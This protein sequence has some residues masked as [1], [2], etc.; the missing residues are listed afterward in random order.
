M[1]REDS[2]WFTLGL[3]AF[4]LTVFS[5]IVFLAQKSGPQAI[6]WALVVFSFCVV[7]FIALVCN[8]VLQYNLTG[9]PI[10]LS[11]YMFVIAVPVVLLIIAVLVSQRGSELPSGKAI[12]EE[13]HASSAWG[14]G[15]LTIGLVTLIL[16]LRLHVGPALGPLGLVSIVF[17]AV[18]GAGWSG[19][20]YYF[21]P[22]GV[23]VRALGFRLST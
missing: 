9:Q 14:I 10:H 8:A 18:G 20:H 16:L 7:G 13:V 1:P 2:L 3:F 21:T 17:L 5:I 4:I 22:H 11:A 19:F 12:A 23:E 15:F 6:A